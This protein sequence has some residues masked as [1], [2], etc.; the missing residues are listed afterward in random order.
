[1]IVHCRLAEKTNSHTQAVRVFQGHSDA[2]Q[3]VDPACDVS[4]IPT[5]MGAIS[6]PCPLESLATGQRITSS[7]HPTAQTAPT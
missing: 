1:M 6:G 7:P 5:M 2:R 4:G 3:A